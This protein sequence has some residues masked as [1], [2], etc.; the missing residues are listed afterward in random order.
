MKLYRPPAIE[1]QNRQRVICL[2]TRSL[3]AFA[4]IALSLA[5]PQRRRR[6]NI[7]SI[8]GV[9]VSII[10]DRRMAQLHEKFSGAVGPTDVLTFQHGEIVISGETAARQAKNFQTS[11]D[12]ELRLYIIHGLLH[13]CGYD[14]KTRQQR[15]AIEQMQCRLLERASSRTA[16]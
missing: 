5:W 12:H 8:P 6:S 14:D 9:L 11:L 4:K 13:L 2:S 1:V 16:V 7:S 3:N 15:A 10:S